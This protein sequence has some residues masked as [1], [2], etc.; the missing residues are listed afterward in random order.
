MIEL[1]L[2]R[3]AS[4]LKAMLNST[5]KVTAASTAAAVEA[6]AAAGGAAGAVDAAKA[7]A[8]ARKAAEA[9]AAD[10]ILAFNLTVNS[11]TVD[12]AQMLLA[13]LLNRLYSSFYDDSKQEVSAAAIEHAKLGTTSNP[14]AL[15]HDAE[16]AGCTRERAV[17]LSEDMFVFVRLHAILVQRLI[18]AMQ[19]CAS[20]AAKGQ[21]LTVNAAQALNDGNPL[22]EAMLEHGVDSERD[23]RAFTALVTT[24]L[25]GTISADAYEDSVRRIVGNEGYPFSTM[26]NLVSACV[27]YLLTAANDPVTD[28]LMQMAAIDKDAMSMKAKPRAYAI[29]RAAV[30]ALKPHL[31]KAKYMFSDRVLL[32]QYLQDADVGEDHEEESDSETVETETATSETASTTDAAKA[33]SS[34]GGGSNSSGSG[35]SSSSSANEQAALAA[36]A[37]ASSASA[38]EAA[39]VAAVTAAAQAEAPTAAAAAAAGS[40]GSDSSDDDQMVIEEVDDDDDDDVNPAGDPDVHLAAAAAAAAKVSGDSSSSSSNNNNKSSDAAK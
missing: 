27:T 24:R 16:A 31:C 20:A 5:E 3:A 18:D 39:A 11:G 34:K 17:L 23:Y 35:S 32:L 13:K 19:L 9:A 30:M 38:V 29:A 25:L 8:E 7:A 10:R 21:V 12:K 6:A 40:N 1:V 36:A 4:N 22:L 26:D 14:T 37:A 2:L 15:K 33:G 28:G